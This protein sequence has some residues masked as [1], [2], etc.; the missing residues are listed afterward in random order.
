MD[1]II[2]AAVI[3]AVTALFCVVVLSIVV[4]ISIGQLATLGD[5]AANR[6]I[7]A[8]V[9]LST[10]PPAVNNVTLDPNI[11]LEP[12]IEVQA[13]VT[14][15]HLTV[16]A[17]ATP[18]AVKKEVEP[19]DND[20]IYLPCDGPTYEDDRVRKFSE[21]ETNGLPNSLSQ[22]GFEIYRVRDLVPKATC[23]KYD[24]DANG[25]RIK[26]SYEPVAGEPLSDDR[27]LVGKTVDDNLGSKILCTD[28]DGEKFMT[29]KILEPNLS[30]DFTPVKFRSGIEAACCPGPTHACKPKK[31]PKVAG[32]NGNPRKVVQ[33]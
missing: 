20:R 10:A 5:Q 29:A 30:T 23:V 18:D 2:R 11:T 15:E 33:R 32:D 7:V 28:A 3:T 12:N 1:N 22:L 17:A 6:P 16:Q 26:D 27:C 4:Y 14:I 8:Q 13:P 31:S 21:L 24:L 19:V 25:D 9:D